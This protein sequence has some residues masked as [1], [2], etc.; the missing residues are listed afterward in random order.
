MELL[1]EHF[2][3]KV[4]IRRIRNKGTI[5]VL[6]WS[7]L[8]TTVYY[9]IA[10]NATRIYSNLMFAIIQTIVGVTIPFAGWLADVRFGRYKIICWS[11]WLMW[12]SSLLLTAILAALQLLDIYHYHQLVMT[13]LSIPLGIGCGD[14]QAN[15]IQFGVD[16]LHDASSN[17]IASNIYYVVLVVLHQ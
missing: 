6:V 17:E 5:L 15:I 11:I 12:I 4:H 2:K 13:T 10:Y 16:Q 14:F 3:P 9:Y 1:R 8:L 7:F